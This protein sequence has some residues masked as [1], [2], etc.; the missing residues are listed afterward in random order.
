VEVEAEKAR[1]IREHAKQGK[2]RQEKPRS[3]K[4]EFRFFAF[5]FFFF[6][7]FFFLLFFFLL[8][9]F[10]PV[11]ESDERGKKSSV[12][13]VEAAE[14][15]VAEDGG[16]RVPMDIERDVDEEPISG[17]QREEPRAVQRKI[18]QNDNNKVIIRR[19]YLSDSFLCRELYYRLRKV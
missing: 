16:D 14:E 8:I 1:L 9:F 18:V 7:F 6:F 19:H 12:D 4:K 10:S 17:V 3:R 2:A 11:N 5:F 13:I 15:A